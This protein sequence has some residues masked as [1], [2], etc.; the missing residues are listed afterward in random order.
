M[1]R[2]A[3]GRPQAVAPFQ[4]SISH[5]QNRVAVAIAQNT[6]VGIDIEY[7]KTRRFSELAKHYFA[8]KEAQAVAARK[9]EHQQQRFYYLWCIKEAVAKRLGDGIG[10]ALLGTDADLLCVQHAIDTQCDPNWTIALA[11]AKRSHICWHPP[12]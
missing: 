3:A 5:S 9:G 11:C 6:P 1:W 10:R 4:I 2:D 7:H 8:A 12:F